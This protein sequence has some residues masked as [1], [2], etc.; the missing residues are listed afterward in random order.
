MAVSSY[1][2]DVAGGMV[3]A[4]SFADDAS[5]ERAIA[6][7]AESDVR[8]QEISVITRDPARAAR[9]AGTRAWYPGK[10]ERGPARI[11]HRIT[12]RVPKD[13]RQRYRT[14]LGA[15]RAV[16][17]AAAGGQPADT[18]AALLSRAGGSLVDQWWQDPTDLFAPPEL[19]GPF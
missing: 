12:H 15:G 14:E 7:L 6:V 19:A 9:I 13:V 17:I 16:I 4:A 8:P 2:P 18:L 5:A 1:L 11:L 3:A 10:D